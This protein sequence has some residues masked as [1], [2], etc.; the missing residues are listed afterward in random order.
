MRNRHLRE[1]KSS[2]TKEIKCGCLA[3]FRDSSRFAA[4]GE[5]ELP[6]V[7]CLSPGMEQWKRQGV[8]FNQGCGVPGKGGG[9][10]GEVGG[11]A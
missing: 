2:W 10:M 11:L 3:A 8:G 9:L 4:Q 5:Y 6:W 1:W 7:T